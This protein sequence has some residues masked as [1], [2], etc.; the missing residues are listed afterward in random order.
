MN[1]IDLKELAKLIASE[2]AKRS[3]FAMSRNDVAAFFGYTAN[4]SALDSI[5][6]SPGFPRPAQLTPGGRDRW[7]RKQVEAWAES[8]FDREG[9]FALHALRNA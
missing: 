2:I 6:E 7:M 5:L 3:S 4:S 1:N 9:K 8:Q